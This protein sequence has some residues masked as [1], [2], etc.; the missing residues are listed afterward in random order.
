[1]KY[2]TTYN[3]TAYDADTGKEVFSWP[4]VV[5]DQHARPSTNAVITDPAEQEFIVIGVHYNST[6][7]DWRVDVRRFK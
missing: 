3:L 2:A 4:N 5:D 1:M 6:A 7:A